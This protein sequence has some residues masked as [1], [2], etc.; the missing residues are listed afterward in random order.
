MTLGAGRESSQSGSH[1]T[2]IIQDFTLITFNFYRNASPS[3]AP[4][5]SHGFFSSYALVPLCTRFSTH[6]SSYALVSPRTCLPTYST[7]MARKDGEE[8]WWGKMVKKNG[9]EEWWGKMVKKDGEEGWWGRMVRKDGEEGWWRRMVRKNGEK[10][11]WEKMVRK[12]NKEGWYLTPHCLRSQK[13][14]PTVGTIY[15]LSTYW[16]MRIIISQSSLDGVE[17]ERLIRRNRV[18]SSLI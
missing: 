2:T 4:I 14:F 10:G 16:G 6:L 11:W 9:E 15:V 7:F 5:W 12:D 17:S 18:C 3:R 1:V 13:V 8:G